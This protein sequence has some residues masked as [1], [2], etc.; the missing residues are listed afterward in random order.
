[1]STEDVRPLSIAES[2]AHARAGISA[3][4]A[5]A[6]GALA[7]FTWLAFSI[8]MHPLT[9]PDEGRYAG[10][11]WEMLRSGDWIV[12]TQDGLPF[13]HK[14]PLFYWLTAA[15]MHV[16]GVNPA[17]ARVGSLLAACVALFGVHVVTRRR[18]GDAVADAAA[19]VLATMPLFFGAAQYANLDLLVAACIAL[20]IV[21]AAD[22]ALAL[23]HGAP[24][25]SSLVFAWA[26]AALG[27]LAKGLIG[28][29]LPGLV[30]VVWLGA[31]R[32]WRT[33]P[34]LLS[35]LGL[36]VFALVAAPWFLAV[37]QRYPE[38]ARYFF[39]HHHFER[40]TAGG[41]NNAQPWWF[42]VVV[43]LALT[44]PWS[45]WLAKALRRNAAESGEDRHD[46]RRLMWAWLATVIVFFSLPQSKPVGYILPALFP[47]AFLVAEPALSAWRGAN[48]A[49][50]RAAGATLAVAV[51]VCLAAVAWMATRYD[52][53]HTPLVRA[54][55]AARAPGDP[56]VFFDEYFFDVPL[57]ARLD[58][59][60]PVIADWH[61]PRIEQRDNWRR[62]LAEAARFVP[63]AAAELLVD[64]ARGF[65]LRCGTKPL[66]VVV[67]SQDEAMV[68]AQPG[69]VR[70]ADARDAALWRLAPQACNAAGAPAAAKG[71]R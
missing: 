68:A 38:F 30:I 35:P 53:D 42:F 16:F 17:S 37:Q 47:L 8:G 10:I 40:F 1:V 27:V 45:L 28:I 21:F 4:R 67:K 9:V 13:F 25:R 24:H 43:V 2:A 39:I 70:V 7:V 19:I 59:P 52:R 12:P 36:V 46:W 66:W 69:A 22:A 61:D 14:P 56:I 54:L 50:R 49:R 44:L 41:F 60:V 33:I 18:A 32:R 57:L 62:E 63:G 6:F 15:S 31:T 51:A 29:V 11:A 58:Q 34:R 23:G 48:P 20:A 64:P 65:A 5:R 26:C 3:P 55:V 71:P